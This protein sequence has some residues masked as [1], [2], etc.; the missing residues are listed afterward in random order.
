MSRFERMIV[1]PEHE[2]NQLLASKSVENTNVDHVTT[3][4][5]PLYN[6]FVNADEERKAAARIA[7]PHKKLLRQSEA[8]NEMIRLKEDM[9][10]NMSQV[11]PKRYVSRAKQLFGT[12]EPFIHLNSR[13]EILDDDNSPIMGS[14]IEDLVQ[15]AI[16]EQRKKQEPVGWN[17]FVTQLNKYNVPKTPLNAATID[18]LEHFKQMPITKSVKKEVLYD[19]DESDYRTPS[20][21]LRSH[22]IVHR[23][24]SKQKR[25]VRARRARRNSSF[26]YYK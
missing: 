17:Y 18:D 7:D 24:R 21:E 16:R 6:Q 1:I 10:D 12:I 8:L 15:Y 25:G 4:R 14:R 11:I 20:P 2:Y 22:G 9:R 13:G 5:E 3:I 19:S 23:S 26:I